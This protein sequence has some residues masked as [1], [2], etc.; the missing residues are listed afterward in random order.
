MKISNDD[1]ERKIEFFDKKTE[2]LVFELELKN[3]N[4]KKWQKIYN[5]DFENPMYDCYK[6]E[7][8]VVKDIENEYKI[9]VDTNKYDIYFAASRR[10]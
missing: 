4:L 1:L 9:V 2:E 10:N 6:I 5:L 7:K 8:D 3:F